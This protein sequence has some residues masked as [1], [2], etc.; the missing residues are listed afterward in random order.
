M[1]EEV[2]M[3]S[4]RIQPAAPLSITDGMEIVEAPYVG[5]DV[6]GHG[7]EERAV[8]RF[9]TRSRTWAV[10]IITLIVLGTVGGMSAQIANQGGKDVEAFSSP[11]SDEQN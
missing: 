10:I 8:V 5:I 1:E 4:F 6:G 7:E 11:P 3:G 9:F 2:E